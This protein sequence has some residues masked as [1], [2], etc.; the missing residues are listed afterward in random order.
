MLNR[1]S[2]GTNICIANIT[3]DVQTFQMV[4]YIPIFILG[5]VCNVAILVIFLCRRRRWTDMMTYMTNISIADC[6]VLISLPFKMYSYQHPWNMSEDSCY[7]LTSIYY[8]NMYVSIQTATAISVVRYVAIKYPFKAQWVMSPW[9]ALAVC[10][11]IWVLNCTLSFVNYKAGNEIKK[12]ES[13]EVKCFQKSNT[14]PLPLSFILTI[15]I[16]GF[17]VPLILIT[18]SSAQIIY[19]LREQRKISSPNEKSQC[20]RIIT[21]NLI[22]FV[23]CFAPIHVGFLIKFLVETYPPINCSLLNG[24]HTFVHIA[25]TISNT[26]CCLDAFCYYF[27]VQDFWKRTPTPGSVCKKNEASNAA[28]NNANSNEYKLV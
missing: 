4:L 17:F 14:N 7:F 3:E 19:T 25:S 1:M 9:K 24:V 28:E 26:N 18:F 20:I 2:N 15:E 10:I 23:I 5:L 12:N 27:V 22:I 16:L 8:V 11:L 6:V 21:A 13:H